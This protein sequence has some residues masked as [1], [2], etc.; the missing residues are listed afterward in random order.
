MSTEEANA[1]A[2]ELENEMKLKEKKT[3]KKQE[4]LVRENPKKRQNT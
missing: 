2:E 1:L 4:T 3:E